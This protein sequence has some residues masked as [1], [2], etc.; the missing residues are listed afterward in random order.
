MYMLSRPSE[1]L[2]KLRKITQLIQRDRFHQ[3][4]FKDFNIVLSNCRVVFDNF[5]KM[6][7]NIEFKDFF[8][9]I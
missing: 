1:K 4:K 2:R 5:K 6:S 7:K 3:P 9:F 8:H